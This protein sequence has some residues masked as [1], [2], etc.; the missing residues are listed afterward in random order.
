MSSKLSGRRRT[1]GTPPICKVPRP[2]PPPPSYLPPAAT[3]HQRFLTK[4][5]LPPTPP[6]PYEP[7]TTRNLIAHIYPTKANDAATTVLAELN[8]RWHLFNGR[9]L[10][11]LAIDRHTTPVAVIKQ[12]LPEDAECVATPNNPRLRETA[13]FL[14][15]LREIRTLDPHTATFYCHSKGA[16]PTHNAS[17]AT[18]LAIRYWTLRML[19]ALLDHWPDVDHALRTH[20]A[21]GIYKIDLTHIPN[22]SITSPTGGPT[23][24]WSYAGSFF[25]F[26]HDCIYTRYRWSCIPDD[27]Y[28]SEDWLGSFLP[29]EQG[30]SLHQPF[31]AHNPEPVK[32]Y[33][34]EI[35]QPETL[36]PTP[37]A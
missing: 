23:P 6:P 7:I 33:A 34:S 25:W 19:H 10:I 8:A 22:L 30:A 13:S 24:R 37:R 5:Q 12:L 27:S 2:P 35:H 15:L 32:L 26:R 4:Q 16:S 28:A 17:P 3:E 36:P 21:A 14:N 18:A 9:K 29:P 31:D 20:A 11:S 1:R